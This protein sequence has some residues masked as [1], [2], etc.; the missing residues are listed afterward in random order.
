[1]LDEAS[2]YFF[3]S[4]KSEDC[5]FLILPH[6]EAVTLHIRTEEGS[7]LA[8]NF[9]CGHGVSSK[10]SIKGGKKIRFFRRVFYSSVE[11]KLLSLDKNVN[12]N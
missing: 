1:M 12:R 9:L 11:K 5:T 3:I 6:E 4:I 7:E 8:F 10:N 2:H